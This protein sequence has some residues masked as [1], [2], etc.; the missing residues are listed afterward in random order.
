M[1]ILGGQTALNLTIELHKLGVLAKH[2]V[3]ILGASPEAIHL[4]E[5]RDA[6]KT[7]M[8][9]IGAEVPRSVVVHSIEEGRAVIQQLGLPI[10]LR[11]SFT[12]GGSGGGIV[13]HE[14]EFEAALTWALRQSPTRECLLEESI[15][16]WKEFELEVMRDAAD[17]CVVVCSIENLDPM[18]V[19]TGDSITVAPQMTLTDRE[20]QAMRD[21]AF[22][23]MRRIGVACGG[24][25][26]QFAVDPKSGR[27]VVIEMNPRVSRSS[28]LASKATGFPIA[29]IATMLAIGYNLEEIENDIT[30]KT[31]AA[32]EPALDYVVVKIPRFAFEKFPGASDTLGT[33]MKS[34]GEV[35]A[36]GRSFQEAFQKAIRSLEVDK[37][38][39]VP[40][41]EVGELWQKYQGQIPPRAL[42][43]KLVEALH[44]KLRHRPAPNFAVADAFRIGMPVMQVAHLTRIDPWFLAKLEHLV[45]IERSVLVTGV[46]ELRGLKN[47][48][49][50]IAASPISPVAKK[51]KCVPIAI[52][53]TFGPDI[54]KSTLAP[55]SSRRRHRICTAPTKKA[56]KRRRPRAKR[57]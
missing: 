31:K 57:R 52:V 47:S 41:R 17:R 39:L 29:K 5:D 30:K 4:A 55:P 14:D 56:T 23:V 46:R 1:P 28:A 9:D 6:F 37:V 15:L 26:V 32:F 21:E 42:D 49:F 16:G 20:F 48:A 36:I 44:A 40:D 38:G 51:P 54:A 10:V 2:R 18:G 45:D 19:H 13:H 43:R 53:K 22:R 33:Q 34:V 25:N 7:C 50:P 8:A 3:E 35:M 12:L 27:R 24:S 11:P